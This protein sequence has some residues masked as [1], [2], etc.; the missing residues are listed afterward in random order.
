MVRSVSR[1]VQKP[2]YLELYIKNW[3][4]LEWSTLD[5]RAGQL[6]EEVARVVR[7]IAAAE[8]NSSHQARK[9]RLAGLHRHQD[10]REFAPRWLAEEQEHGKALACL[11]QGSEPSYNEQRREPSHR[12]RSIVS[13]VTL[14]GIR[15]LP[16][17][18]LT[19]FCLGASAEYLTHELYAHLATKV[20][21]P[22]IK[23][24]FKELAKQEARHLAF[25]VAGAQA[26]AELSWIS[27]LVARLV[28]RAFWRPVA[29]DT[30]GPAAW[31]DTIGSLLVE[32]E[33]RQR[34]A[35]VDDVLDR[36]PAMNG[37]HLM[38]R[39]LNKSGY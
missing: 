23:S 17:L 24:L 25:Y 28:L 31:H 21:H 27:R 34:V 6:P 13:P 22:T 38:K 11:I 5:L 7:S 10:V 9:I 4:R 1:S 32:K 12:V 35:R 18:D 8:S 36:L 30:L 39:F 2:R 3:R 26:R 16:G 15:R 37:L 29:I 14:I 19:F 33:F 20:S